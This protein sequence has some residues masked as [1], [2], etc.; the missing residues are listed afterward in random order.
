MFHNAARDVVA[1]L[2]HPFI[3]PAVSFATHASGVDIGRRGTYAPMRIPAGGGSQDVENMR[4]AI[5]NQNP[6]LYSLMQPML[7]AWGIDRKPRTNDTDTRGQQLATAW[8]G[9]P[10]SSAIGIRDVIAPHS[11][12]IEQAARIIH[13]DTPAGRTQAEMEHTQ[14]VKDFVAQSKAGGAPVYPQG[15]SHT[16][17]KHLHQTVADP[18]KTYA[19]SLLQRLPAEYAYKVFQGLS[20]EERT[21]FRASLLK[22]VLTAYGKTHDPM[23]KAEIVG[24]RD[25]KE[26]NG[27]KTGPSDQ[28]P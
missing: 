24:L 26:P 5:E 17:I 25:W 16:Q 2:T 9:K 8:L 13:G 11:A 18:E 27:K 22:K 1:G 7:K 19:S 4:A 6:A 10:A 20:P 12:G 15:F 28:S 21:L 23:L 3:G 14:A